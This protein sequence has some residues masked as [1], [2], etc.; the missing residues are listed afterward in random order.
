[1]NAFVANGTMD[2]SVDFAKG[3]HTVDI[4]ES[5]GMEVVFKSWNGPTELTEVHCSKLRYGW[6]H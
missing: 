4:L 2:E 3:A 1:M 5:Y 6:N